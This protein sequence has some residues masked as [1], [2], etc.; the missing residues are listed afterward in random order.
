MDIV[1][2]TR[3][4]RA[5]T[6]VEILITVVIMAIVVAVV[7]PS[8]S[9]DDN[10]RLIG[11]ANMVA[12]DIEFAQSVA[13]ANPDDP[14]ALK[15]SADGTGYWVATA[16]DPDAPILSTY[17]QE[18]Y[19]ITFGE[20]VASELGGVTISV[21]EVDGKIQFDGFGRLAGLEDIVVTV[22]NASGS[23]E[24]LVKSVTGVVEIQ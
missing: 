13:L 16:L 22:S 17:S 6:L 23:Q 11:A 3:N 4:H 5:F 14:G 21:A 18:P 8:L 7:I 2:P 24:I 20:G 19:L 1:S 10:A 9:T 15:A 12:S